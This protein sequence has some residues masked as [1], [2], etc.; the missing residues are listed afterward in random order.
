[1]SVKSIR[2]MK[3]QESVKSNGQNVA[4]VPDCAHEVEGEADAGGGR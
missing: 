2:V 4:V 1:M 3:L